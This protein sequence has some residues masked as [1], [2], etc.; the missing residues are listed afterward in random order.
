[1]NTQAL[2]MLA[3]SLPR[4][5][6]D[7]SDISAR[8]DAQIATWLSVAG[9]EA[10][11]STGASHVIGRLLSLHANVPHGLTSCVLL[12]AVMRWNVTANEERQKRIVNA[13]GRLERTAGD[14]I[15]SLI[16]QLGLPRR[17]RDVNVN[18]DI[19]SDIARMAFDTPAIRAN[20][21]RVSSPTDVLEILQSAW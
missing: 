1:V 16:A 3:Q 15:D 19:L 8:S 2:T 4:V 13:L 6:S 5:K 21:R 17:L 10:G 18:S 20:P 14:A 11:A 7:P 9:E 12:P